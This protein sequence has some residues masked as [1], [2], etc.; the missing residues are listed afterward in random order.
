MRSRFI[1]ALLIA[2]LSMPGVA[3]VANWQGIVT[4]NWFN[5]LNWDPEAIPGAG[6][7]VIINTTT[8]NPTTLATNATPSLGAIQIGETATGDLFVELG[9]K[10]NNDGIGLLGAG[11]ASQGF[12][13]V[14]DPGSE[15][16]IDHNLVVAEQ[17]FAWLQLRNQGYVLN[18]NG[19]IGN[20][21]GSTGTVT[22]REES[23]WVNLGNLFVGHSGE[24]SLDIRSGSAVFNQ[25]QAFVG[26]SATGEGHVR[27]REGAGWA[28][29]N[30]LLIGREGNGKL[31]I[32]SGGVVVLTDDSGSR[33][34]VQVGGVGEVTV[35]GA[36]SQWNNSAGLIIGVNGSGLLTMD[37]G[38]VV[39]ANIVSVADLGPGSGVVTVGQN[40][41]L[42]SAS[43]LLVGRAS[44]G[45]LTIDGGEVTNE[46]LGIIG[47]TPAANGEVHLVWSAAPGAHWQSDGDIIVGFQGSGLLTVADSTS[48]ESG[49]RIRIASEPGSSGEVRLQATGSLSASAAFG[50][51]VVGNGGKLSGNGTVNGGLAA[52]A[53]GIVSPGISPGVVGSLSVNGTLNLQSA[54]V[55]LEYELTNIFIP[56]DT[57][58]PIS[59]RINV[60]GD[61]IL[62]GTLNANVTGA[63][64]PGIYTLLTYTGT[65]TDNGLSIETLPPPLVGNSAWID[66]TTQPGEVRL[67]VGPASD[68]L[69]SDRFEG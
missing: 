55:V 40:A 29:F 28:S 17:G 39:N 11:P 59:D 37:D 5:G 27:V 50:G 10:L 61:L 63:F 36:G 26:Y 67:V 38:A 48:V 22:L 45:S 52:M 7:N 20:S 35:T 53:G 57:V 58:V 19:R 25:A 32:E 41:K 62:N 31:D 3:Q 42:N 15:W 23:N 16:R 64:F 8:P 30:D 1:F 69:F 56:P 6:T 54:D 68:D 43:N 44:S 2:S 60:E 18:N 14:R 46:Q 49:G 24:G 4:E 12:V 34:G 65:L 13:T 21:N 47:A 33:V 9:G 66:T 51:T